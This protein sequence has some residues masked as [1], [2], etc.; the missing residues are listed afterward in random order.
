MVLARACGGGLLIVAC[1]TR[2]AIDGLRRLGSGLSQWGIGHAL[3]VFG[4]SFGLLFA[5]ARSASADPGDPSAPPTVYSVEIGGGLYAGVSASLTFESEG[6]TSTSCKWQSSTKDRATR[7]EPRI[8]PGS[9][10]MIRTRPS[11]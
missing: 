4:L 10:P 8:V 1:R 11:G 2:S 3:I 7:G 6:E 9:S 5:G